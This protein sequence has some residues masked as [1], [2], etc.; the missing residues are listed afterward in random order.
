MQFVN[1]WVIN[2]DCSNQHFFFQS[3]KETLANTEQVQWTC[4]ALYVEVIPLRESAKI[5]PSRAKPTKR[6][7][8]SKQLTYFLITTFS[9]PIKL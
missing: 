8:V 9:I 6:A 5:L 3:Q 1:R 2:Y 7:C 4:G